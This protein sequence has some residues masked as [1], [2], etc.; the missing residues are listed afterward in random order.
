MGKSCMTNSMYVNNTH[1]RTC[2]YVS[3][4]KLLAKENFITLNVVIDV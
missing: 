3:F 1:T 2:T 4:V